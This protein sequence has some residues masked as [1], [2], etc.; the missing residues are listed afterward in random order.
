[1]RSVRSDRVSEFG[2]PEVL[3]ERV[4]DNPMANRGEVVID[5]ALVSVTFVE[6]Q[7]RAS[8]P[9]RASMLPQL[10]AIPG[11]G[12]PEGSRWWSRQRRSSPLPPPLRT[13]ANAEHRPP[14][15]Q[16]RTPTDALSLLPRL[17][18]PRQSHPRS[19]AKTPGATSRVAASSPPRPTTTTSAGRDRARLTARVGPPQ[20]FTAALCEC[21]ATQIVAGVATTA[22]LGTKS[23]GACS[24][25]PVGRRPRSRRSLRI[26]LSQALFA[27][28]GFLSSFRR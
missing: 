18:P 4:V 21:L 16:H 14:F 6:T 28:H 3:V 12:S 15:G 19:H 23:A 1:M 24:G 8:H 17:Q 22:D 13:S 20:R 11:N 9:P 2:P 27:R 25:S 5:V 10:P 26:P 7:I